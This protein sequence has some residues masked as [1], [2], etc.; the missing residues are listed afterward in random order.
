[1]KLT[2][3]LDVTNKMLNERLKLDDVKRQTIQNRKE[4]IKEQAVN[5]VYE[6]FDETGLPT[7]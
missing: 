5:K 4:E 1:M 2:P 6:G 3:F 7:S